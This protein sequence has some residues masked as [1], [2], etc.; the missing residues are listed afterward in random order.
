MDKKD[1]KIVIGAN[2]GDEGKG[3]MTDYFAN[4]V[5][6][7]KKA[8]VICSNGGA[9]RGH[10]VLHIEGMPTKEGYKEIKQRHIFHHFGSGTFEGADT[11]LSP[12]FIVNPMQFRTEYEELEKEFHIQPKVYVNIN[13]KMSTPWDMMLNQIL[14]ESR[15]SKKHG[16]CGMGIYETIHRYE[17]M[18]FVNLKYIKKHPEYLKQIQKDYTTSRLREMNVTISSGW[19]RL[20]YDD[21]IVDAFMED[22]D[23]FFNHVVFMDD[24][25]MRSNT[26]STLIFECAQGL[27]L[28][29][30]N[31]EYFPHLTPS[32]TGCK[33]PWNLIKNTFKDNEY[34]LEVCYVSRS[35]MTRHGAGFFKSECEKE[36]I[37]PDMV[38][39]TNVPNPHQDS[40]RYGTLDFEDLVSR[41]KKDDELIDVPHTY[42]LALTH[43]NEYYSDDLKQELE[44]FDGQLYVSRGQTCYDVTNFTK[45]IE[46]V[47]LVNICAEIDDCISKQDKLSDTIIA[48]FAK[49]L[50]DYL[51]KNSYEKPM[52]KEYKNLLETLKK[53]YMYGEIE[54]LDEQQILLYGYLLGYMNVFLVYDEKCKKKKDN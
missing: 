13:C 49:C 9:Q 23:F 6:F 38:D 37:N 22:L 19:N 29:Q 51:K 28:D 34:D 2:F 27:L 1:I 24:R 4:Q 42:S 48:K 11:Y 46:E 54:R 3:L 16:S 32:N 33:N 15:S 10:T 44:H 25:I 52:P 17:N 50:D 31:M 40:L 35:Y 18:G 43:L 26:Y 7:N 12:D 5:D 41:T 8:L 47:H 30:S 45:N 14:E 36:F 21:G 53:M 39:E 20:L